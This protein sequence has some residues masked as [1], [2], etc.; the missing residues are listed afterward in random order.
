MVEGEVDRSGWP[1]ARSG[2]PLILPEFLV[3]FLVDVYRNSETALLVA[4][5][6]AKS[7]AV[8]CAL[9]AH[10]IGPLR[11]RGF[12]AGVI[13]L[14]AAK[15]AEL[16]DLMHGIAVASGLEGLR[17]LR[18]PAPGRVQS[19]W[20]RVEILAATEKASAGIQARLI[21]SALLRKSAC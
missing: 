20:G 17:F 8:S 14:T 11:K 19:E 12:R 3:S 7:T 16:K 21:A 13:S 6:Q 2:E 1:S 4:R 18:S 10:L 9:L 5:K 15:A